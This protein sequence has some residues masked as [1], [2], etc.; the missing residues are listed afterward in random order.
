MEHQQRCGNGR[1]LNLDPRGLITPACLGVYTFPSLLLFV[2]SLVFS[3]F[4]RRIHPS[5][6]PFKSLSARLFPS[7]RFEP[8][9]SCL[10]CPL[11]LGRHFTTG[12]ATWFDRNSEPLP[13][14]GNRAQALLRH[15]Q[16]HLKKHTQEKMIL[17]AEEAQTLSKCQL[18][19]LQ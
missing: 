8:W 10:T 19:R 14:S 11:I 5:P 16:G 9:A 3:A 18:L 17:V 15:F 2:F 6:A 4:T 13:F 12:W 7:P 1:H